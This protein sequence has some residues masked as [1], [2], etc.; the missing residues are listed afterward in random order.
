M[1]IREI[2]IG[3]T[4]TLISLWQEAGLLVP[5][6]NPKDDIKQ[7]LATATS[8]L[9]VMEDESQII[10]SVMTG[11]DGHRGWIYYL[12][13]KTGYQKQGYGKK[14]VQAAEEWLKSQGAPKVHLLI[15]KDN[16]VIQSFYHRIGYKTSDVVMMKKTL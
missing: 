7:A 10:G 2:V 3:D 15:R 16:D 13:V 1:R 11:Y 8:T 9:L 5:W 12:A 6:S 4:Q 14:L